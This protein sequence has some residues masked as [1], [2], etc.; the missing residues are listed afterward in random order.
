VSDLDARGTEVFITDLQEQPEQL[1]RDSGT[2]PGLL[3]ESHV[4]ESFAD[5][6]PAIAAR[7]LAAA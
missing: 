1:L 3:P 2:A 7:E 4:L 6:V 5:V